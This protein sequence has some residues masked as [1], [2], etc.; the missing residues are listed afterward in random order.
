MAFL[1]SFLVIS[2]RMEVKALSLNGLLE[3]RPSVFR[4]NRGYFF[5]SFNEA[6]FR[7]AG[8]EAGF[9]QDN[10]SFS[11][12]GTIR[13]LHFQ[14]PP[15]AQ[16]KL[17]WVASGKV[18]DVMVDLRKDSPDFRKYLQVELDS[19]D[20]RMLYIPPGFAH[21]F[22]ALEDSVFQYKCTA[23]YHK[24]AEGGVNPLDAGLGID[25]QV[26]EP[27][28]SEKDLALPGIHDIQSPF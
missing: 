20:F 5:E 7:N 1:H 4:D 24:S 14:A 11:L 10:Q 28:I 26:K 25:W 6:T 22:S 12:K 19:R 3:I 2:Q 15:H 18:L 17:V 8:V 27:I 21:G 9:V 23:V 16:G 13:G